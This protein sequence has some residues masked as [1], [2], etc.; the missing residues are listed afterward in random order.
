MGSVDPNLDLEK[1]SLRVKRSSLA[2]FRGIATPA[3]RDSCLPDALTEHFGV[4]ARTFQVLSM[5]FWGIGFPSYWN[6]G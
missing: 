1:L 2:Y 5:T 4:Q 3:C 6:L